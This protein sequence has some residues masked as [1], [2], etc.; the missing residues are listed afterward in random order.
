MAIILDTVYIHTLTNLKDNKNQK[1]KN[2][3]IRIEV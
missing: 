3:I 2:K 1:E